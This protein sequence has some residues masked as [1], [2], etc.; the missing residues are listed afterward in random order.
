MERATLR[1]RM[2]DDRIYM[3]TGALAVCSVRGARIPSRVT[4]RGAGV[5]VKRIVRSA[6]S[7]TRSPRKMREIGVGSA[8]GSRSFD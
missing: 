2:T 4:M 6:T 3:E 8:P 1:I 7:T 5:R